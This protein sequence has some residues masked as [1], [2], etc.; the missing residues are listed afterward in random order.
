M[1]FETVSTVTDKDLVEQLLKSHGFEVCAQ[2]PPDQLSVL[3]CA[4]L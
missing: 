3:A 4:E 1:D 2:Q